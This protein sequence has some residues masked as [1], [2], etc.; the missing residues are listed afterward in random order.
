ME[1]LWAVLVSVGLVVGACCYWPCWCGWLIW[2]G[3]RGGGPG[4]DG[5]SVVVNGACEPRRG[6][7]A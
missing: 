6:L 3:A 7:G 5:G 2:A 4:G 1:T